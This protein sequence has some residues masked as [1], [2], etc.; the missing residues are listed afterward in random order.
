MVCKLLSGNIV[1][2]TKSLLWINERDGFST[3]RESGVVLVQAIG[4]WG[5]QAQSNPA[6]NKENSTLP[7]K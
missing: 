1:T 4:C 3:N 5:E 2:S 7:F 6:N